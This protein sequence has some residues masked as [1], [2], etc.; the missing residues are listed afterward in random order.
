MALTLKKLVDVAGTRQTADQV[1]ANSRR[2]YNE[3]TWEKIV[4]RYVAL[5]GQFILVTDANGKETIYV[6]YVADGIRFLGE[7]SYGSCLSN[8]GFSFGY[9]TSNGFILYTYEEGRLENV[10]ANRILF[11]EETATNKGRIYS[12]LF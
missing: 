4:D 5:D 2:E 7:V 11:R 8:G 9:C 12:T 10:K 6:I 3:T 1:K